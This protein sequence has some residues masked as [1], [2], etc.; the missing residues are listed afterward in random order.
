[1]LC[2][3]FGSGESLDCLA[4]SLDLGIAQQSSDCPHNPCGQLS[5]KKVQYARNFTKS[6]HTGKEK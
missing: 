6:G 2:V 4:Q 1:M 5:I 3:K